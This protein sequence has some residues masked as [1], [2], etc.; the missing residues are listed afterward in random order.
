VTWAVNGTDAAGLAPNVRISLSLDGG[1]TF[2]TELVA[3]TPNDGSQV[4]T[5]P[6]V[7]A[8]A[9]RIRIEAVGN[10]FFDVN[11]ASFAIGV[12]PGTTITEGPAAKSF[13]LTRKAR[14]SAAST[15]PGSTFICTFDG[16]SLPCSDRA[17]V[18]LKPG[19]HVFR[20]AARS[21]VGV[22]DPTPAT[23]R[24]AAPFNDGQ[25]TRRTDGWRRVKDK[26]SY[27]GTYMLTRS[28]DQV[29]TRKAKRVSKVALVAHTG[30]RFGRVMVLL[31][32]RRLKVIDL[33]SPQRAKKVLIKVTGLRGKRSGTFS[34]R[35]L[36]NK[37]VRIDG[38]GLLA[39]VRR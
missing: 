15:M 34:I 36:D 6:A 10:Y 9:A 35:T 1:L 31:D 38:L 21:P 11:D 18:K 3:S 30:P 26:G 22:V 7:E 37:P 17:R 13:V 12:T 19:T 20:V 39:K 2:P 23:R 8:A 24:F 29:L 5:M 4:V 33:S 16:K 28:K 32:G 25:L 27:R 14:F